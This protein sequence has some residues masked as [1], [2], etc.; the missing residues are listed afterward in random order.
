MALKT[1]MLRK[2][3]NLADIQYVLVTKTLALGR[4]LG[5]LYL[6][7]PALFILLLI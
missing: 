3:R 6:A 7:L 1:L 2:T 4:G 5:V